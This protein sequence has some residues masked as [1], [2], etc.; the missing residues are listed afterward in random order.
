M[1]DTG[2]YGHAELLIADDEAQVWTTPVIALGPTLLVSLLIN[3]GGHP[4]T[5]PSARPAVSLAVGNPTGGWTNCR[6]LAGGGGGADA[7]AVRYAMFDRPTP[8][9]PPVVRLEVQ[10][11]GQVVVRV[12]ALGDAAQSAPQ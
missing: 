6:A 8:D 4:A 10:H 5:D 12:M 9:L 3:G 1:A 2:T 11:R 7:S